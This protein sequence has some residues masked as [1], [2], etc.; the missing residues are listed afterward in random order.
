M[1]LPAISRARRAAAGFTLI[2][3]MITVAIAAILAAIAYPSY[4]EHVRKSRRT[5]AKTALLDLAAR[6]ERLFSTRNVYGGTPGALGYAGD[7]FPVPVQ[8][9]GQVYYQLTVVAG[10]PATSYTA[11]AAPVGAQAGDECGSYTLNH[12]GLQGNTG[13][14]AGVASAQCW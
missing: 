7:V 8:S 9:G 5:D 2:E 1:N 13:M 4:T 10:N 14:R 6:Q 3:L 12:L 11:T